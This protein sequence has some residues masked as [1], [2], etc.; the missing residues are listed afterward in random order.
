MSA[1]LCQRMSGQV[2]EVC[3][4]SG[5]TNEQETAVRVFSPPS[6]IKDGQHKE[7]QIYFLLLSGYPEGSVWALRV[8]W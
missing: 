5:S 3:L 8:V 7:I 6:R 2:K 1:E 4:P